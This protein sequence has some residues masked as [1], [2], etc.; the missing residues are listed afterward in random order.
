M[1]LVADSLSASA[2]ASTP[3]HQWDGRA[4]FGCCT[5]VLSTV[6]ALSVLV[7]AI[8]GG[9]LVELHRDWAVF[10]LR[11]MGRGAFLSVGVLTQRTSACPGSAL[12]H[13]TGGRPP[14]ALGPIPQVT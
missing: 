2:W 10:E 1:N 3:L 7:W 11:R 8:N 14:K 4:L 6:P 9:R 12:G 5:I 13:L